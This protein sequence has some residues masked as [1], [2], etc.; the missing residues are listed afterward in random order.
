MARYA[1]TAGHNDLR[2]YEGNVLIAFG[3]NYGIGGTT[4]PASPLAHV[5]IPLLNC[6]FALDDVPVVSDGR[7]VHP[8]LELR[9]TASR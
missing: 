3:A 1:Y 8:V 5:D 7:V 9:Q 4:R 2:S 6:D